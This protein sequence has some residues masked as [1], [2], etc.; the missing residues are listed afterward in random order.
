MAKKLSSGAADVIGSGIG[1]AGSLIDNS[2]NQYYAQQNMRLQAELNKQQYDH[3]FYREASYNNPQAERARLEAA[4]L[5]P[6]LMYEN[7]AG[8]SSVN[9]S[10]GQTGLSHLPSSDVAGSL[11]AGAESMARIRNLDANTNKTKTETDYLQDVSATRLEF[12]KSQLLREKYGAQMDEI[13]TK[14]KEAKTQAD[15][16]EVRARLN[17][18]NSDIANDKQLTANDTKRA[19]AYVKSISDLGAEIESKIKLNEAKTETESTVQDLNKSLQR[20]NNANADEKEL[21]NAIREVTG[22]KP[23]WNQWQLLAGIYNKV[24]Y[25]IAPDSPLRKRLESVPE[26]VRED[27]SQWYNDLPEDK[28]K[29]LI[30]KFA[31]LEE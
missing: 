8:G 27:V 7:G 25:N 21:D 28:K 14:F 26:S 5:N 2:M 23:G 4:G 6:A 17:K 16:D 24:I 10:I 22:Y 19:D 30:E 13:E 11:I 9:A 31:E 18:I 15:L 3:E 1:V 29:K 20:L 12:E